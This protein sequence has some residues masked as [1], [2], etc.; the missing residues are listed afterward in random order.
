VRPYVAAFVVS[1]WAMVLFRTVLR[2]LLVLNGSLEWMS[3]EE[4][5]ARAWTFQ[6]MW[7]AEV[8][9]MELI[10]LLLAPFFIWITWSDL[11]FKR[12]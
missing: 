10:Y 3:L 7:P 11:E 12:Q 5:M 9:P 6:N 8:D 1:V 2:L 4:S